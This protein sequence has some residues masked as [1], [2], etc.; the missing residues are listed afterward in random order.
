[1]NP[2]VFKGICLAGHMN[3]SGV[4]TAC[5]FLFVQAAEEGGETE[6]QELKKKIVVNKG[7]AVMFY[8]LKHGCDGVN[9]SCV[10]KVSRY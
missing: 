5:L 7:S 1:V 9:P 4:F 10:D 6:F 3:T 8:N 2:R